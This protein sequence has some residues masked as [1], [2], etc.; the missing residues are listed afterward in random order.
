MAQLQ[1]YQPGILLTLAYLMGEKS[2]N[3]TTSTSRADFIQKTLEECY[4]AY[5]WRFASANATLVVASG[6]ATLPTM[7]D[8]SH[9]VTASYFSGTTEIDLTEI[10]PVDKE[11]VNNGD[12]AFWLQAQSDGTY[13]L[14]T[15]DTLTSV[16]V[17]YQQQAPTLDSAGTVGTPYPSAMTIAVGARRWVKQSQNPDADISQEQKLFEKYQANDIA[18][19]Q[20]PSPRRARR[21]R[22]G[23]IGSRTGEF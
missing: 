21:S 4:Q 3:A 20:I 12:H 11:Q 9:F 17:R 7:I 10:D 18:A 23:Q 8:V 22:Q 5:P 15:K 14:N 16:I 19:Q 13:L 6:I 1:I 2:V